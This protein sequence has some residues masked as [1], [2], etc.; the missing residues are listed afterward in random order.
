[1]FNNYIICLLLLELIKG[2]RLTGRYFVAKKFTVQYPEDRAPMSPRFRGLH[3]Q[4]RYSNGEERCIACKLCEEAGADWV[5][6]STGFA[7]G[8]ATDEDLQLMRRT[9]AEKV[10]VKAEGGV[11]ELD[12]ARKVREIGCTR[13]GATATIAIME[14]CY[15]RNSSQEI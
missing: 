7:G 13:F 15:Q 11:R 8:G 2:L 6:T 10:Q 3:A 9:V 5:K 1:M 14:D 4:R 12:R